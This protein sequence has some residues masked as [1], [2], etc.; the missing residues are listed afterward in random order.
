MDCC[1]N[2]YEQS[3]RSNLRDVIKAGMDTHYDDLDKHLTPS[4]TLKTLTYHYA[5]TDPHLKKLK[6]QNV[7]NNGVLHGSDKRN[8]SFTINNS[9]DL[10]EIYLPNHLAMFSA[11]DESLDMTAILNLLGISYYQPKAIFSALTQTSADDVRKNVRNKWGHFDVIE[12]P[13]T[14]FDDCFAKVEA[15]VRS[16]GLTIEKEKKT[17]EDLYD[18]QTKGT[19]RELFLISVSLSLERMK[20]MNTSMNNCMNERTKEVRKGK[21][22]KKEK[23]T[24]EGI[25]FLA[26]LKLTSKRGVLITIQPATQI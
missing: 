1:R 9:V 5:N 20:R 8:Y 11:F 15:L 3:C 10:A 12:W 24:S 7:N 19:E 17:L 16:L 2:F 4:C 25:N 22:K 13:D 21:E 14:F 18:W 23:T 6:F 26:V